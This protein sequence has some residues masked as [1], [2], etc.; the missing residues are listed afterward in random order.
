MKAAAVNSG[1]A[2]NVPAPPSKPSSNIHNTSADS[3][4]RKDTQTLWQ[5][6]HP[7]SSKGADGQGNGTWGAND[8]KGVNDFL[9]RLSAKYSNSPKSSK[10]KSPDKGGDSQG[11]VSNGWGGAHQNGFGNWNDDDNNNSNK[12]S[13]YNQD[14]RTNVG[15]WGMPKNVGWDSTSNGNWNGGA[16]LQTAPDQ[17]N[18]GEQAGHNWGGSGSK[19]SDTN[20]INNNW[21][22]WEDTGQT[23]MTLE[24]TTNGQA[25][26]HAGNGWDGN[27]KSGSEDG[28]NRSAQ[29]NTHQPAN[30]VGPPGVSQAQPRAH[31]RT[32]SAGPRKRY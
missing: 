31:A 32:K 16:G 28:S 10:S 11:A 2:L 24:N 9:E 5:D 7:T 18:T 12:T 29:S 25:K 23:D 15:D 22:G 4:S 8:S 27:N 20:N 13:N 14:G 17:W 3:K 6:I 1:P 21:G 30:N 19:K 26:S